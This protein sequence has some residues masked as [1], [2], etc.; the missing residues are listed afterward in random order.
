M[1]CRLCS[2]NLKMSPNGRY[3]VVYNQIT[4]IKDS[5]SD[6]PWFTPRCLSATLSSIDQLSLGSLLIYFQKHFI[7][8]GYMSSGYRL[9]AQVKAKLKCCATCAVLLALIQ[10][11]ISSTLHITVYTV[12]ILA[13]AFFLK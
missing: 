5:K 2:Q 4:K 11:I 9:I 10:Y 13:N 8:I 1:N 12:Y 6:S 3:I 7:V